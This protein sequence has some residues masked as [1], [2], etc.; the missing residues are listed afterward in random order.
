MKNAYFLGTNNY[1]ASFAYSLTTSHSCAVLR[2]ISSV[3][4]LSHIQLFVTPWT[5]EG[6]ASLSITNSQSLP[7]LI[8]IEL[9]MPSKHLILC[10]PILPLPSIFHNVRVFSRVSSS[11]QVAKG[12]ELQLQ[13]QSFQFIFRTDFL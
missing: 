5:A 7:K 9:V 13:H 4:L 12:L 2:Y 1:L 6:Q 8:L 11:H 10:C 3:Q